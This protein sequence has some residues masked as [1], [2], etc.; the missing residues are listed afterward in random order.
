MV[1][2]PPAINPRAPPIAAPHGPNIIPIRAPVP[3]IERPLPKPVN[4]L[5]VSTP[6]PLM[7]PQPPRVSPTLSL[8][9][10]PAAAIAVP[11][12]YATIAPAEAHA[13]AFLNPSPLPHLLFFQLNLSLSSSSGF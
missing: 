7:P 10:A 5:E 3:P 9:A 1:G 11:A 13:R 2:K 12:N 8:R 4:N 6:L